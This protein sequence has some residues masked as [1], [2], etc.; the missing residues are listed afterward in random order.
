MGLLEFLLQFENKPTIIQD[1]TL[2]N[3]IPEIKNLPV[4]KFQD[5]ELYWNLKRDIYYKKHIFNINLD[6]YIFY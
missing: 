1:S 4:V 5:L 3:D 2:D 6:I